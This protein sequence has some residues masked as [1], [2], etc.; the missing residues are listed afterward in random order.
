MPETAETD[1]RRF[2][3]LATGKVTKIFLE[4]TAEKQNPPA[5]IFIILK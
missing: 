2:P 3:G 4:I 1:S 5:N